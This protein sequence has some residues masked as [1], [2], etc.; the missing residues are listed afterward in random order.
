MPEIAETAFARYQ[1]RDMV[2]A[3]KIFEIPGSMPESEYY[4]DANYYIGEI[5]YNLGQ[6]KYLLSKMVS[7]SLIK[8]I[9]L[10]VSLLELPNK[11]LLINT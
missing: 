6:K 7:H 9:R 1:D 10:S 5:N 11:K 8:Q 3:A 2:A 4:Y